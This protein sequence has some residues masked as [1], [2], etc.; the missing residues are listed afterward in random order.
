MHIE[1]RRKNV[2]TNQSQFPERFVQLKRGNGNRCKAKTTEEKKWEKKDSAKKHADS[3]WMICLC[4]AF[5]ILEVFAISTYQEQD[6]AHFDG[7]PHVCK[8]LPHQIKSTQFFNIQK[9]RMQI[10]CTALRTNYF[11]WKEHTHKCTGEWERCTL[12]WIWS[13]Q[14]WCEIDLNQCWKLSSSLL[15]FSSSFTR[16]FSCC[17]NFKRNPLIESYSLALDPSKWYLDIPIRLKHGL[18]NFVFFCVCVCLRFALLRRMYTFYVE[19]KPN[20]F[21]PWEFL[22]SS[23]MIHFCDAICLTAYTLN[24]VETSFSSSSLPLHVY[25]KMDG[26][27]SHIY[28]YMAIILIYWHCAVVEKLTY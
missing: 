12:I 8:I 23:N 20:R 6:W 16:R 21:T 13:I 19:M 10:N 14:N 25:V 9:L 26:V 24:M 1:R 11:R 17:Q 3:T 2:Q 22:R 15:S 18:L 7:K 4:M 27:G 28:I 5:E